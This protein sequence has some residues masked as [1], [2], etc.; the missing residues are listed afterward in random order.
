MSGPGLDAGAWAA[1]AL[2]AALIGFSKTAVNGVSLV[3]VV[4][5]ASVLPVRSSTGTLLVLILVGDLYAVRTYRRHADWKVL[6]RLVVPVAAGILGGT[7]YLARASDATVGRTIGWVLLALLAWQGV[8]RLRLPRS[9]PPQS[10]LQAPLLGALAGFTSMVA[11]AG[12]SFMSI[13]LL[14]ADVGVL[15]FLGTGAWF[16]FVVN[17]VK[18]PLAVGLGLVGAGSWVVLVAL[19]PVVLAG[20][21]LGRMVLP[22][23]S[24]RTFEWTVVVLTAVGAVNLI[25]ASGP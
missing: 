10:R 25:V 20:G 7:C 3:S 13:Y 15:G 17:L 5:F 1:L 2:G 11:N 19:A 18:L 22:R 24:L 8:S 12:G 9:G 14:R 23:L 16:F 21:W 4:L 6:R